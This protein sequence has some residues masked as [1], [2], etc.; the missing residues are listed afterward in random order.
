MRFEFTIT[1]VTFALQEIRS[2]F[3]R[4]A[5]PVRRRGLQACSLARK[6]PAARLCALRREK[7]NAPTEARLYVVVR[8]H[9]VV[10]LAGL[11]VAHFVVHG[12]ALNR[13]QLLKMLGLI[14]QAQA[15]ETPNPITCLALGGPPPKIKG[16]QIPAPRS[17][18]RP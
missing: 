8:T 7:M 5:V 18:A 9:V 16:V 11:P 4:Q 3:S 14:G 1:N 6:L 12:G 17:G 2:E 13:G 15:G 10:G